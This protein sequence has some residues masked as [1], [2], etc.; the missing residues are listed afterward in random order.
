MTGENTEQNGQKSNE[1]PTQFAI[2]TQRE[3]KSWYFLF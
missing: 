1:Y 3:L 2:S